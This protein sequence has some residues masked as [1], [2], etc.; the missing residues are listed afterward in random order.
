MKKIIINKYALIIVAFCL[1]IPTLSLTQPIIIK[2][3]L[4]KPI[5]F[6]VQKNG[7]WGFINR[8][9]KIIIIPQ[10]TNAGVFSEGLAAV[11]IHGKYGYINQQGRFA[12]KPQFTKAGKFSNGLAFVKFNRKEG[13]IDQEGLFVTQTNYNKHIQ[14]SDGTSGISSWAT[15]DL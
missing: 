4:E 8:A 5:L 7:K 11:S 9:G 6:P 13:F 3:Q 12:I 15:A 1:I 2:T 14:Y 10:Y